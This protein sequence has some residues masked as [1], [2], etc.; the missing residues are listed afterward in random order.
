MNSLNI[1]GTSR[2][3]LHIFWVRGRSLGRAQGENALHMTSPRVQHTP[4]QTPE[5]PCHWVPVG[6]HRIRS[7][8]TRN[9]SRRNVFI[10]PKTFY[11]M[12]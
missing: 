6:R 11:Y 1:P 12:V 7:I 4:P 3:G 9:K 8:P 2:K 5:A 10:Y